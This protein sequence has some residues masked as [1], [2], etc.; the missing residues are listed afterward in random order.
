MGFAF[1]LEVEGERKEWTG[2][3]FLKLQQNNRLMAI[4][5]SEMMRCVQ[6]MILYVGM[7]GNYCIANIIII[8]IID[9]MMCS[10]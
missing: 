5:R 8:T 7:E 2:K 4:V 10:W 1:T 9:L 3:L 6:G